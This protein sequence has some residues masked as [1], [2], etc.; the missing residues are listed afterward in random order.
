ML[1]LSSVDIKKREIESYLQI[2]FLLL[3]LFSGEKLN[4]QMAIILFFI[5]TLF[6]K[7]LNNKIGGADL[8][9]IIMLSLSYGQ[10]IF[11]IIFLS[12]TVGILYIL[13]RR[14]NKEVPFIPFLT[15]GVILCQILTN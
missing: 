10:K 3:I 8:K 13:M 6:S 9:I 12:S 5:F 4:L 15:I 2:I 11:L 1:Y 14:E 7:L